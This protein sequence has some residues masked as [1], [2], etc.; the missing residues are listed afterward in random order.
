MSLSWNVN[1]LPPDKENNLFPW[2]NL[3]SDEEPADIYAIGIQEVPYDPQSLL[4]DYYIRNDPWSQQIVAFLRCHGI[5]MVEKIRMI[6]LLLIIAVKS[7][8][9]PFAR[10]KRTSFVRTAFWGLVGS[11]GAVATRIDLYG[12]SF[13]FINAHLTSGDEYAEYRNKEYQSIMRKLFFPGCKTSSVNDHRFIFFF[14]DMNYRI[15]DL[16]I[17]VVKDYVKQKEVSVLLTYDQLNRNKKEEK[18]FDGF[19]EGAINFSPT[20]KYDLGTSTFDTSEKIRKPAWC[21]RVLWKEQLIDQP[22]VHLVEYTSFDSYFTSD[23]K[24]IHAV[25]DIEI[26]GVEGAA[27]V[28]TFS[29]DPD[30]EP[31]RTEEDGVCIFYVNGY[32][33]SSWDWIGLYR[34]DFAHANDYYTYEWSLSGADETGKDGCMILFDDIPEEPGFYQLGYFSRKLNAFLGFTRPF[35]IILQPEEPDTVAVEVPP[36]DASQQV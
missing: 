5:V 20:Y 1:I 10:E 14:G 16:D 27:P 23:H 24:P 36:D 33:T 6:G 17:D 26:E 3:Y 22:R 4:M 19:Q 11:K 15:D 2:L 13:C 30:Y 7:K 32:Q 8:H 12:E 28:V 34:A 31:W 35:E 9:L 29:L 25:F 18:C 21:D